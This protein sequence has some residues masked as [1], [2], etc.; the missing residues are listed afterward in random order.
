VARGRIAARAPRTHCAPAHRPLSLLSALVWVNFVSVLR[1]VLRLRGTEKSKKIQ[2]NQS[3]HFVTDGI[4]I[5]LC[6]AKNA[7]AK[8][9]QTRAVRKRFEQ[10][11]TPF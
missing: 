10:E 8:R 9:A 11:A 6:S 2:Q 1:M 5:F 7:A 4:V 3:C